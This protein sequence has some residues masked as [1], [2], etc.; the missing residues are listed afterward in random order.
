MP[1]VSAALRVTLLAPVTT[2]PA[3]IE[4]VVLSWTTLIA[5]PAPI[6]TVPASLSFAIALAVLSTDEVADRVRS[7][8]DR[9]SAPT[10]VLWIWALVPMSAMVSAREPA[11]PNLPLPAPAVASV[12]RLCLPSLPP[13]L[14]IAAIRL[15]PGADTVVPTPVLAWLVTLT[16]LIA[17]AA[18]ML[19]LL[20]SVALPDAM[21]LESVSS[22]EL[23][24]TDP[25]AVTETPSASVASARAVTIPMA[26]AAA[27]VTLLPPPSPVLASGVF[28]EPESL[29]L[30]LVEVSLPSFNWSSDFLF[31]SL[32]DES[33]SPGADVF[34]PSAPAE[35]AL[36]SVSLADEPSAAKLTV[37]PVWVR[38]RFSC[39]WTMW[40][41][42]SIATEMPMPALPPLVAP[43]ALVVADADC[44]A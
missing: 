21:T 44:V 25:V 6:P 27:T 35:L 5:A 31:T 40:L 2:A 37:P 12:S 17:T 33:V 13:E 20:A 1:L 32:L 16:R 9:L 15:R 11:N 28:E 41:A 43:L 22:E 26:T 7:L 8:P 19:A 4:A 39:D 36:A 14:F 24:L 30:A 18:P 3:S 42:T 29:P 34:L 23:R 10:P 38:L